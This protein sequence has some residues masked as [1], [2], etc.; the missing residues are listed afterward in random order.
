[1]RGPSVMKSSLGH[2]FGKIAFLFGISFSSGYLF[3][4]YIGLKLR[5]EE[6][7]RFKILLYIHLINIF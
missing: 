5:P 1:M 4:D 2:V 7:F 3:P 6:F